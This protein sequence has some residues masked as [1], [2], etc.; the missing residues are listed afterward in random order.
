MDPTRKPHTSSP[1]IDYSLTLWK[2]HPSFRYIPRVLLYYVKFGF[3]EPFRL[4]EKFLY[5]KKLES[6]RLSQDPVFILGYYRSGTTHLQEVLLEDPRFA[7]LNFYQCYFANGHLVTERI[8]KKLFQ[9]IMTAVG[10]KHPAHGVPFL[11]DM[12]GE[13]DVSMVASGFRHACSWGQLFPKSFKS[14]F[15]QFVYFEGVKEEDRELFEHEYLMLLKRVAWARQNR[16]LLLKSPPMTARIRLLKRLFP[17]AKFIYIYR[18]PYYVYKSNQK[19]WKTFHEQCLQSSSVEEANENILWSFDKCLDFY[20][21][22]KN[23]LDE[24]QLIEVQYESFMKDPIG[25][26]EKIYTKLGMKD[27]QSLKPRFENFLKLKHGTNVDRYRFSEEDLKT[28]ELRLKRWI[29]L[30]GYSRPT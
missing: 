21:R 27:F 3:F 25:H 9:K 13:E 1:L 23:L 18:S 30:Y 5:W 15:N 6:F 14:L 11:F 29:E 22:D 10:F 17:K 12:P 19:L 26:L 7:F 16:P 28:V 4:I 8:F 2:L 24:N 20:E